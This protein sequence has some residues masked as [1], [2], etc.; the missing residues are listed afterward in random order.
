MMGYLAACTLIYLHTTAL[1]KFILQ[2]VVE[3][4][5]NKFEY[6]FKCNCDIDEKHKWWKV[7]GKKC[8]KLTNT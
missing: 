5:E 6:T 1:Q 4:P 8:R 2:I 7:A 3:D